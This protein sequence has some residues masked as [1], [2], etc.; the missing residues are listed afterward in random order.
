VPKG[1]EDENFINPC[2]FAKRVVQTIAPKTRMHVDI[3]NIFIYDKDDNIVR[4]AQHKEGKEDE[5]DLKR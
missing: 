4:V 1:D 5:N 3:N 2:L